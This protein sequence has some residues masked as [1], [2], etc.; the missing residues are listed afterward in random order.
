MHK[1][2][3]FPLGNA[4]TCLVETALAGSCSSTTPRR[5]TRTIRAIGGSI[6]RGHPRTA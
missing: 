5:L 4:D 6:S 1:L 2:A 3:F